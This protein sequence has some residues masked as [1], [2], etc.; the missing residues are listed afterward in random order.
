MRNVIGLLLLSIACAFGQAFSFNDIPFIANAGGTDWERRVVANGGP[1]PTAVTA[2]CMENLR[3][4]LIAQGITNKI[5]SLCVFVPD[6]VIAATTPL[7]KHKGIDPWGNSN[8]VSGDLNIQGLKGDGTSKSLNPGI[9]N[10]QAATNGASIERGQTVVVSE[11]A[12]NQNSV[13]MGWQEPDTT[14]RDF[15]QISSNGFSSWFPIS[16]V[17]SQ[18]VVT[19]DFARV[20]YY[21]GNVVTNASGT[22]MTIYV[23]SP[24]ES[25]KI[26]ATTVFLNTISIPPVAIDLSVFARNNG[27][28]SLWSAQR[29]SVAMVNA[30]F[31]QT[32]S[33]NVWWALKTCREC[34]GGGTGDN[35]HDYNQRIVA[36]G[37]TDISTTTSNALRTFYAGLDTDGTLYSIVAANVF[38]PDNLT[39]AR[40][41]VVWQGGNDIWVN[42]LFAASNLTVNGLTGNGSTKYLGTG[43][44]P[45]TLVNRGFSSTSAGGTVLTFAVPTAGDD[46]AGAGTAANSYFRVPIN[47]AGTLFFNCWKVVTVNTEFVARGAPGGSS[48]WAGYVSGNRTAANAIR[49]DWVTNGVHNIATNGTGNQTGSTAT[50]TNLYAF[51]S[52]PVG[53]VANTFSDHTLSFLALHSG[54]TQTASSNLWNRVF[55]LRSSLGGGLPP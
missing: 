41:P 36:A 20:G 32:E 51:A 5:H 40:T 53:G 30:G 37:G 48:T 49:M 50:I 18:S 19:N 42:N 23:A 26:L 46:L 31:T 44:N 21:S 28:N 15:I 14:P 13:T 8:F 55:N 16:N 6:S 9:S 12:T 4:T 43:L 54:L 34:L 33:S 11:S 1:Q 17:G 10:Q 24:L 45:A 2:T 47:N 52:S 27:T 3:L 22:N 39:A 7:F 35:I 29:L 38:V 25:H